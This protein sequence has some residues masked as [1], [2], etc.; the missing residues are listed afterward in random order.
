MVGHDALSRPINGLSDVV[1]GGGSWGLVVDP[2]DP[3]IGGTGV[4]VTGW[5]CSRCWTLALSRVCEPQ[6][7][8]EL[9]QFLGKPLLKENITVPVGSVRGSAGALA[10]SFGLSS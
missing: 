10:S 5:A 1:G 7:D 3:S 4:A 9:D 6:E 2:T 8:R